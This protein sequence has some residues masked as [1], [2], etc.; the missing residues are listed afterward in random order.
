MPRVRILLALV[1][2]MTLAACAGPQRES[3]FLQ[4][5]GDQAQPSDIVATELSFARLAREKGHWK[6]YAE[7][8]AEGAIVFD[9]AGPQ[10]VT[11]YIA[12]GSGAGGTFAWDVR[13]VYMSCDGSHAASM[14]TFTQSSGAGGVYTTIWERQK[15]GDYR[16]I[17]DFP[18][19]GE[20]WE[21]AGDMVRSTVGE[22]RK[23]KPEERMQLFEAIRLEMARDAD[24]KNV[25]LYAGISPDQSFGWFAGHASLQDRGIMLG[26]FTDGRWRMMT[27]QREEASETDAISQMFSAQRP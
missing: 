10:L 18:Q 8:A 21:D 9:Q 16:F 13:H 20:T 1:L 5:L 23:T 15:K 7:Y 14:G 11:D 17:L 12:K 6:A 4:S 27:G 25:Q 3:R 2:G 22:C 19:M 24:A 26:T